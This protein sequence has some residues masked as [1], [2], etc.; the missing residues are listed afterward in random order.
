ML[1]ANGWRQLGSHLVCG[2]NPDHWTEPTLAIFD[3]VPH[4][5]QTRAHR[6]CSHQRANHCRSWPSK[7][8]GRSH[9]ALVPEQI[10]PTNWRVRACTKDRK[11]TTSATN[12]L[13]TPNRR[14]NRPFVHAR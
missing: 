1:S 3:R 9:A 13:S 4:R 14:G 12:Q 8:Y 6:R 10:S 5:E 11:A 2:G 7:S